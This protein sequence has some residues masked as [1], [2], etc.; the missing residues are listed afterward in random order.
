MYGN[1]KLCQIKHSGRE[2]R[3]AQA[4]I[5]PASSLSCENIPLSLR[6]HKGIDGGSLGIYTKSQATWINKKPDHI[7]Y[8]RVSFYIRRTVIN[9]WRS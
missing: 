5:Y 1:K 3:V 4:G 8:D 7:E 9:S 6:P 2:E